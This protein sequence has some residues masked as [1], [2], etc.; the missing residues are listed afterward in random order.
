MARPWHLWVVGVLTLVWNGSGAVTIAMAQMGSRLDMDPH[1]VAY[2]ANQPFWFV[3]A[4]GAATALPVA[5]GVALLARSRAASWLFA[6]ALV[7]LGATNAYDVAAGTSLALVDT[8]W[9]G[10]T[11]VLVVVAVLQWTYA[12]RLQRRGVLT[13]R[14]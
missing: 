13:R 9:R 12:W 2:Y 4:T 5:A 7:V 1:E 10:L 3:L 6:L 14:P 11:I 8:G